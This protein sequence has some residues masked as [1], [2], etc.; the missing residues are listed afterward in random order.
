MN[1]RLDDII[2]E[3][4]FTSLEKLLSDSLHATREIIGPELANH[5]QRANVNIVSQQL[6][7]ACDLLHSIHESYKLSQPKVPNVRY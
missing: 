3:K 7:Q 5:P 1:Y 4:T 2:D 6:E